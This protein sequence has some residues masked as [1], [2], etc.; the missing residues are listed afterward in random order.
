MR[1]LLVT[2]EYP[3]RI[4]GIAS[5]VSE[6]QSALRE[7]GHDCLVLAPHAWRPGR[8]R[9]SPDRDEHQVERPAIISAQPVYTWMLRRIIRQAIR[10]S[11]F[12][13][14]HV[15]GLR[16]LRASQGHG[17]PV[18]FTNHSSGFLG[19]LG[20]PRGKLARAANLM[21]A[22]RGVI[23][24]STELAEATRLAG[25]PGPVAV[26][27]NGVDPQRFRPGRSSLRAEWG[28]P[29]G[30][31][32]LLLPRRLVEKNGVVWFARSLAVLGD[33]PWRAVIAGAGPEEQAMRRILGEA[34]VAQRCI[35]LG[36]VPS[37]RMPE[38]Y[39]AADVAV[40][41]SLAEATSIAGLEAMASGLPVIAT[42]VG[43]LPEIVSADETGL[44]VPPRAPDAIAA[45]LRRLIEVPDLG[46]GLGTAGRLAVEARFTWK[47]VAH[48]TVAFIDGLLDRR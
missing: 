17:L 44:L 26:I 47:R 22:A 24:P 4:G 20:D 5:H 32:V 38:V 37:P 25:Y 12:D 10:D 23:A 41:P 36:A 45:A 1:T 29:D 3:P 48:R 9:P 6:L 13:A 40:L 33:G 16:P 18:V 42:M 15:H 2:V 31:T 8:W 28:I 46:R 21:T 11:R 14:I 35:F 34:G 7:L 30:E 19:R 39:R 43:G 27:P